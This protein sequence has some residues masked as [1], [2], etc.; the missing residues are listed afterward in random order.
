M[1]SDYF[2]VAGVV[3][4]G[5]ALASLVSAWTDGRVPRGGALLL[6][7]AGGLIAA[8]IITSPTGYVIEDIPG[9]FYRVIGAIIN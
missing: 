8:A 6:L 9:A 5:F 2:L 1:N 4:G 7:V 3:V